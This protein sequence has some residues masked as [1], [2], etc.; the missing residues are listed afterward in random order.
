MY[1]HPMVMVDV[2]LCS[3]TK[4]KRIVILQRLEVVTEGSKNFS[5][6]WPYS[7]I[8]RLALREPLVLG[9]EKNKRPTSRESFKV[10]SLLV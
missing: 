2:K 7:E 5:L 1:F 9:D 8:K 4:M 10:T 3:P 6:Q